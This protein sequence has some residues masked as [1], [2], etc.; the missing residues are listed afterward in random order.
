MGM[1]NHFHPSGTRRQTALLTIA[2]TAV[3]LMASLAT[4]AHAEPNAQMKEVL[5][6][7]AVLSPVPIEDTLPAVAKAAPT[8]ASAVKV[9]MTKDGKKALPFTGSTQDFKINVGGGKEVDARAYIPAG[10]GP[11]PTI[12]YIHGGGWVIGSLDAYDASPRALCELTKAVIIST[13]YRLAPANKF[14]TAHDDTLTAYQWVLKN[15]GTYKGNPSK[16]AVVGESAGGNMAASICLEAKKK[17]LQMPVAQ[18]L[19]Y[20]VANYDFSTQ[21]YKENEKTKPLSA[22]GMKWFFKYYL[23]QPEDGNNP[24]LSILQAADFKGLPP[25]TIIAAEIDPL[26]TEGM[27]LA[28]KLKSAGVSVT[29]KMYPGVTHEFFGMGAVVDEAAQAEE[30]AAAGLKKS[31]GE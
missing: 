12:L 29:Y 17:G 31:F 6:A 20:P 7:Y 13:D 10:S 24:R 18:V 14:P 4:V 30:F 28:D 1:I 26:R 3:V 23:A 15:A 21:S 16:V 25:A 2:G 19:V 5:D 11:F 8:I 22:E 9:V 27:Q